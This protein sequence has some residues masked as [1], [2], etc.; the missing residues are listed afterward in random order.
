[1]DQSARKL[2]E[3]IAA[4]TALGEVGWRGL[5]EAD[6]EAANTRWQEKMQSSIAEASQRAA[7]QIAKNAEVS[8]QQVEQQLEQRFSTLSQ[9]HS[10]ISSESESALMKLR[11]E[12]ARETANGD[13]VISKFQNSIAQLEIKRGDFAALLQTAS[14]EW[15]RRSEAML[16]A[17]STELNRRA[18]SAVTGLSQRLQPMLEAA[19]HES[20]EKLA[21]EFENRFSPQIAQATE[22][23]SKLAFDSDRAEKAAADHQQRIWQMS[24]QGL[25]ESAARSKEILAGIEKDFA[26]SARIASAR[27]LAELETRA[28]ETSHSTFETLYKSADWYEKKIQTQMQSTL[29]KGLDQ[30]A[31][32]LREKAAEM[33]GLFASELDHYSR[34]YVEHAHGQMQENA[35]DAAEQASQK[36][37][38]ASES[39][40]AQF[41]ERAAQM[42]GEQFDAFTSRTRG[43]MEQNAAAMD[44]HT[45]QIRAS[46]ES[47][48]R[49]FASEFQNALSK[50]ADQTLALG[51]QELGLQIDLAKDALLIESQSLERHFQSALT[52]HGNSAVDEH[53]QRLEN[54]SNAW[55]LTT[56]TKLN[57]QSD[58][59]ISEM[60][61]ATEKK[62]KVVCESVF[63]EMGEI[64]RQRLA[65]LASPFSSPAKSENKQ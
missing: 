51:K 61:D 17:Q 64:L 29:E 19:G 56:V 62:L 9:A 18:E 46:L 15:T 41:T 30:A 54:A 27:W 45:S 35:R 59:L 38:D 52:V 11:A 23:L 24:D 49:G 33:S 14:D 63:S 16:D 65:G 48:A 37:A 40:A 47:D 60:S 50:H 21:T 26:E 36:M 42:S 8:A 43:A 2:G 34:S 6:L 57:Q 7:E 22:I 5:L 28:T 12:I 3:Q 20:I 44:A 58:K 53:K 39:V 55:L 32:R 4:A 10:Q 1:M 13:A 31:A 25:Q